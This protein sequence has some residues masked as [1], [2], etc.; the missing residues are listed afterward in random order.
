MHIWKIIY[1]CLAHSKV[2]II[3]QTIICLPIF[4]CSWW[5]HKSLLSASFLTI[6]SNY[7][8]YLKSADFKYHDV[9]LY[10][11]N[12]MMKAVFITF[13][14]VFLFITYGTCY[15]IHLA[16]NVRINAAK[17]GRAALCQQMIQQTTICLPVFICSWWKHKSLLC[18]SFLTIFSNYH[19]YLKYADFTYHDVYLYS[20]IYLISMGVFAMKIKTKIKLK[21]LNE[22]DWSSQRPY[23]IL[24]NT[25]LYHTVEVPKMNYHKNRCVNAQVVLNRIS[26]NFIYLVKIA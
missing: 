7:H 26:F 10:T 9:Y 24:F 13:G 15:P 3:Q 12:Y 21:H 25:N 4:I 14:T 11:S 1:N 20:S 16:Y 22:T 17:F 6:F 18:A 2:T 19:E 8:E 5:K 23:W